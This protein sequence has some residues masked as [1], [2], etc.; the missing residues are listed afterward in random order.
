MSPAPPKNRKPPPAREPGPGMNSFDKRQMGKRKR[1]DA[2]TEVQEFERRKPTRTGSLP[3]PFGGGSGRGRSRG[4][5]FVS[6]GEALRRVLT[7]GSWTGLG[8]AITSPA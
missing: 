5:S 2:K 3:L 1:R 7:V 8:V 6:R 4:L